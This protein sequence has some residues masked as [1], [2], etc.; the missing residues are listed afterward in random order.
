[1]PTEPQDTPRTPA[2]DGESRR[3]GRLAASRQHCSLGEI[4][5]FSASGLRIRTRSMVRVAE[6]QSLTIHV[7]TPW[8]VLALP[9]QIVW[10]RKMGLTRREVGATF[11][12]L[13]PEQQ[14]AL[15]ELARM[16]R[17]RHSLDPHLHSF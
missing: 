6:G 2:E 15:Q 5:D 4:L 1:M 11:D 12:K 7:D 13:A 17:V 8:G 10:V 9:V 16:A 14:A 3:H